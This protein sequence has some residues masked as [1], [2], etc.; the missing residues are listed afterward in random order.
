M[1]WQKIDKPIK[2]LAPMAGY[3]D[4]AFRG[5]CKEQG[6]DIL[7][8]ELIS[9]DAIY[10]AL[11]KSEKTFLTSKTFTLLKYQNTERP[12]VAQLF[13]KDPERFLVAAKYLVTKMKFDG[14]DINMGCAVNKVLK[15]GHGAALL[16]DE[17]TAV[18][19]IETLSKNL[20][21][22]ISVKTRLGFSAKD[23]ILSFVPKLLQ[24]GASAIIIHGRTAKQ[25]FSGTADWQNIYKL[26]ELNNNSV[27]I[28]NGDI[29]S[30]GEISKMIGNLDGVG[31]GRAAVGRPW[32]FRSDE[33]SPK[34]R[35]KIIRQHA[36]FSFEEKGTHGLIEFRK[37][38]LAYFKGFK[39][40]KCYRSRLVAVETLD[41]LDKILSEINRLL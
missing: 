4:S 33:V 29:K 14:I 37:H 5:I 12:I 34:E 20:K 28:G 27:I 2:L 7:M 9:A 13:G 21:I 16:K 23:Q 32:I 38:L 22:P 19:I 8:T 25:G 26:K 1:L 10:F 15:S 17:K 40:A 35:I 24:S 30:F 31:I 3:T 41:D 11:K 36:R 6:A 39:D 18:L